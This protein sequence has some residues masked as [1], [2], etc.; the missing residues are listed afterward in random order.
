MMRPSGLKALLPDVPE[1]EWPTYGTVAKDSVYWM[2]APGPALPLKPT[3]PPFRNHG[4]HMVSVAELWCANWNREC[5][6]AKV[7]VG[8]RK[9][10][11]LRRRPLQELARSVEIVM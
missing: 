2:L 7:Y 5:F 4:N 9:G 11:R 8:D 3:P 1:S 10:A 6:R